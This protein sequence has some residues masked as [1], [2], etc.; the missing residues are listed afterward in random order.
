MIRPK[1]LKPIIK[2]YDTAHEQKDKSK[3][4]NSS[5]I[6]PSTRIYSL[7]TKIDTQLNAGKDK[8]SKW[9]KAIEQAYMKKSQT[10]R[11]NPDKNI[12]ME[13]TLKVKKCQKTRQEDYNTPNG[14]YHYKSKPRSNQETTS[15]QTTKFA[16]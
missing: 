11:F 5:E 9:Y 6:W 4:E 7:W 13:Q 12:Q 15:N 16:P 10:H 8:S 3:E 1:G 2:Q 14:G